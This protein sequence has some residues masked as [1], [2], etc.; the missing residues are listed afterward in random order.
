MQG[1]EFYFE[2]LLEIGRQIQSRKES[3]VAITKAMLARIGV[4]DSRLH[5]FV[6]LMANDALA[7]ATQADAEIAAGRIRGH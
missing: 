6:L 5:S 3:S 7:Q 1:P 4:V 2:D